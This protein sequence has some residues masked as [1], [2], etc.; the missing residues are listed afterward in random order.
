M[1]G[2]SLVSKMSNET[3]KPIILIALCAVAVY[4]YRRKNFGKH[5]E[6][7]E[8]NNA[9]VKAVSSGLII[10]FYDGFIGPGTGSFL[11][12]AFVA[13][14]G[15]DF[16]HASAHAKTVN[17]TTNFASILFFIST[18]HVLWWLALPMAVCN[19]GGGLVGTKL[20]LLKGNTLVRKFFLAVVIL[21]I[22]RFAYDVLLKNN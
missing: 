8:T 1:V 18:G 3:F 5:Q 6:N 15:F 4:T 17:L 12:L 13:L 14:L 16:L 2:S 19:M 21:T 10:G 11:V 9:M 20:A 7:K 22:I